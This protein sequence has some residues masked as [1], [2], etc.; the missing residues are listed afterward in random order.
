MSPDLPPVLIEVPAGRPG[1]KV[2]LDRRVEAIVA[3][4]EQME[5]VEAAL[6]ALA[7]VLAVRPADPPSP[8]AG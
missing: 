7:P 2:A 4:P 5:T 1:S 3:A 6:R 8:R